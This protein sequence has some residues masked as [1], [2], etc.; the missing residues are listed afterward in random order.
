MGGLGGGQ[1]VPAAAG[2][3]AAETIFGVASL[4]FG[5]H[6][7]TYSAEETVARTSRALAIGTVLVTAAYL[8]LNAAYLT[9]F[10]STD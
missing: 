1:A 6:M 7:V 10:R 9:C 8:A 2:S 3:W 4:A 5:W